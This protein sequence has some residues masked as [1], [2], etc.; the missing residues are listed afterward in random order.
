M[1]ETGP[2]KVWSKSDFR[3]DSGDFK[4]ATPGARNAGPDQ[5]HVGTETV[6]A[7]EDRWDL[8]GTPTDEVP[9]MLP[10]WYREL[11]ADPRVGLPPEHPWNKE[12]PKFDTGLEVSPNRTW[13]H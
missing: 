7:Y 12:L 3:R 6:Q 11:A 5:A 4:S 8:L 2:V 13:G 9:V 10:P 1:I